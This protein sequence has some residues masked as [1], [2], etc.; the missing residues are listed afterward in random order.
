MST[1]I[2][3][4]AKMPGDAQ[5]NGLDHLASELCDRWSLGNPE[6]P[7]AV[8]VI[9]VMHVRKWEVTRD[10]QGTRRTPTMVL[11]RVEA[12]GMVGTEVHG[13][14]SALPEHRNLL[15]GITEQRT[16]ATPLPLEAESATGHHTVIGGEDYDGFD[17]DGAG[18]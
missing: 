4:S 5:T 15:Q 6:D 18:F 11:S 10:D 16:G 17:D 9:G 7:A 8:L 12:L 3:I 1:N 14:P 13:L 2:K